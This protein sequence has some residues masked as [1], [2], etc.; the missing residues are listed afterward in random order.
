MQANKLENLVIELAKKTKDG[1]IHWE[2]MGNY[3][4]KNIRHLDLINRS[5]KCD[6]FKSDLNLYFIQLIYPEYTLSGGEEFDKEFLKLY[7]IKSNKLIKEINHDE[8]DNSL[9][10]SLYSAIDDNNEDLK[11]FLDEI[12]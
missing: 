6:D 8:V 3:F 4:P 10:L 2:N 12:D 9:L 7:I 11:D 1:E 5:F